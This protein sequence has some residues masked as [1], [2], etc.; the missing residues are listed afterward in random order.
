MKQV[1]L[2][3]RVGISSAHLSGLEHGK[4]NLNN[5]LL[6]R[7]ARELGVQPHELISGDGTPDMGRLVETLNKLEQGDVQ[8]VESFALALLASQRGLE[9]VEEPADDSSD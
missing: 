3:E 7:I 1:E 5:H 9:Q 8:R 6:I 2:A 4:K